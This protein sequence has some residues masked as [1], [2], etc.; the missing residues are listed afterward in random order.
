MRHVP[1][2]HAAGALI[3]QTGPNDFIP[4]A[5]RSDQTIAIDRWVMRTVIAELA[6]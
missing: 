6:Q 1:Q 4:I 2:L 5:E 3:G